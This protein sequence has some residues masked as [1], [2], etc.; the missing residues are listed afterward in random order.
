MDFVVT[1]IHISVVKSVI[2]MAS[3]VFGCS[4]NIRRPDKA[5]TLVVTTFVGV[6]FGFFLAITFPPI[7]FN[8]KAC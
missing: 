1:Q 6:V 2:F 3:I 5:M 8:N 7:S 4:A